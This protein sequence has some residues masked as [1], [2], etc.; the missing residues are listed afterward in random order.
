MTLRTLRTHAFLPIVLLLC[1]AFSRFTTGGDDTVTSS[2]LA[3]VLWLIVYAIAAVIVARHRE[4]ARELFV[5]AWPL[6]ALVA[7]V[8]CSALWSDDPSIVLRRAFGLAGTTLVGFSVAVRYGVR[9]FV[10]L[11]AI[12]AGIAAVFSLAVIFAVPGYGRMQVD[13]PG[14]WQGIFGDKNRLG[15]FMALGV[16]AFIPLVRELRGGR[17]VAAFAG[18]AACALVLLGSQSLTAALVAVLCSLL[19]LTLYAGSANRAAFV[20][21]ATVAIVA[22]SF[23]TAM[24]FNVNLDAVAGAFGRDATLTGRTGVW[25]YV[26]GAIADHPYLG[27]GYA[28]FW[29]PDGAFVQYIPTDLGWRPYH[30]HDGFLELTLDVGVIGLVIFAALLVLALVRALRR[31]HDTDAA[32][33]PL[34]L[35]IL[36]YYIA[37][38]VTESAIAKYNEL[39]WIVF[40]ALFLMVPALAAKKRV[41]ADA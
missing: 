41:L 24:A 31:L 20:A 16:L 14:A 36:V 40:V 18:F 1:A 19:V 17:R 25:P 15:Q 8:A 38:N 5:S 39:N 2:P 35:A 6:L 12:A 13:Y 27:F 29:R 9:R 32:F 33:A 34:P 11:L 22:A 37:V 23:G 7:V 26:L 30:A 10:T 4:R 3:Q 21:F 28:S